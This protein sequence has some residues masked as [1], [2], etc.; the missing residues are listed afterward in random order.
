MR[1]YKDLNEDWAFI[2]LPQNGEVRPEEC[3]K[4]E[5]CT[6]RWQTVTLP[7]TYNAEDGVSGWTGVCEG[8]EHYYRGMVCYR[9]ELRVSE[10][11][12]AGRQ[13][14]LEFGAANTVAEVYVNGSPVGRHEGGYSAFRFDI[15][16]LLVPEELNSIAVLVS[17]AP[18]DYIA[19]ITDQ[20]D[21]TKMGGLY[22]KVRLILVHPMHIAL[23]DYGSSGVYITPQIT[24]ENAAKVDVLVKLE[25]KTADNNSVRIVLRD[26][27]GKSAAEEVITKERLT[28]I[29]RVPQQE[30]AE[31]AFYRSELRETLTIDQPVLWN[32]VWNPYLYTAVI[33]LLWNDEEVDEV[34]QSFGIRSYR[35]DS[36]Q[37]FFLNDSYL[38]VRGA[39]YHQDS[40]ENG[41]AMT[42]EQ[43][44]RDFGMMRE[45]GCTGVRMAH[46]QHAPEEYDI[47]DR[48]GLLVWTE[49]G[50]VNK[51]SPDN[52]KDL[53]IAEGF[54][55]NAKQQLRELIRQNYNHPSI[56]VWGISN[57]L[58]Q[59]TDEI[60]EI[61]ME[62]HR[63]A[64][65]EDASRLKTF[66][67]AQFWGRFLTLPG[68]V[69]GYNRYFGW[70]QDAGPVEKFGEWLDEYHEKKEQ[71]PICVSE[72]GG[73]GAISQHKDRIDW[74]TEIDPWGERHYEN[75]QSALHEKIWAQ[76]SVRP[77]L[78]AKFVWCMFDFAS[79]GRQEGDTRGQNDKG[80]V[81]RK[82][83]RKDAFYFYKSLWNP[84]PMVHI[85]E[86]RFSPRPAQVP[87]LKVYSNAESVELRVN[88]V[89]KGIHWRKESEQGFETVFVWKSVEL[90]AQ[91]VNEIEAVAV[92][93]DGHKETD[94]VFWIGEGNNS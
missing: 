38:E 73:G 75:Y 40:Y 46:Y 10:E 28:E 42:N 47:C 77:Y 85:T 21:F 81:T 63:I 15:T 34:V 51:M 84:E 72:Y 36:E 70:Y 44:E 17:N 94:S 30:P 20:G 86:K 64:E 67:D 39:N 4:P 83:V 91:S 55:E 78:W 80:L 41:W 88:G 29:V 56:V 12:I 32:G 33:T 27:L 22:R 7:H 60:Y 9:K 61:Y 24:K 76:F 92:F 37:G 71:R 57:E 43:R 59:M 6:K 50:I 1:V 52:V 19:P 74:K 68:D 87:E 66:A 65:Q 2:K 49:L 26:A 23:E 45:M 13:V 53:K 5:V 54:V 62:L 3:V 35:I 58:H 31:N 16:A 90:M 11:E 69:V 8:G 14:Y 48:L 18:T 79:D 25:G 93:A 82:R 89:S